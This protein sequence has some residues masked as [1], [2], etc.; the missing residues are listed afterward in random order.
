VSFPLSGPAETPGVIVMCLD[1]TGLDSPWSRLAVVFNAT[2][3]ETTQR[4]GGLG[5]AGWQLHPEL[6]GSADPEL[7][8]AA[9]TVDGDVVAMTAP[10]RSVAVYVSGAA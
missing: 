6:T 8:T 2:G 10:A 7:R 9:V 1:A 4:V 5:G 3:H